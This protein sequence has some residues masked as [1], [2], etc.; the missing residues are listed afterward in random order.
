MSRAAP[1]TRGIGAL[2][3]ARGFGHGFLELVE[4][5]PCLLP[6]LQGRY[7]EVGD[8][9]AVALLDF[10]ITM[11]VDGAEGAGALALAA[12][13]TQGVVNGDDPVVLV[14]SDCTRWAA[15][16]ALLTTGAPVGEHFDGVE[17][18]GAG[19]CKARG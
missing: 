14:E 5:S 4:S 19:F 13:H 7:R 10:G 18:E 12:G 16:V 1:D 2:E 3:A 11:D 15:D 6:R 17:G 9:V 8:L